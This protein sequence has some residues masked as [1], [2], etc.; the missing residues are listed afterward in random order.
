MHCIIGRISIVIMMMTV[1][2]TIFRSFRILI[3][4]IVYML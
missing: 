2:S 1:S 4:M 3:M